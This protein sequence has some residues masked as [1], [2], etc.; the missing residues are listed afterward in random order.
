M[1]ASE[2]ILALL[3]KY[4]ITPYE[5]SK[6]TGITKSNFSAWKS[7]PTSNIGGNIIIKLADY[8]GV[9]CNYLLL[10]TDESTSRLNADALAL[11]PHKDL[12]DAY[13]KADKKTKA[14]IRVLL[15]LREEK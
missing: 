9:S 8:L 10:G 3:E 1:E 12:V 6:E 2:R 11:L 15:G 14:A 7:K 5:A 13:K 4:H